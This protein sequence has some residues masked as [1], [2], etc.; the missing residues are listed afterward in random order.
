MGTFR[1]TRLNEIVG[2]KQAVQRI[3]ISLASARKRGEPFPH[4]LLAGPPGL[5]KTTFSCLIGNEMGVK[6]HVANGGNIRSVKDILPYLT[7]MEANEILFIDEIHRI[8]IKVEEFLYPVMEDFK[9]Q[10]V[11]NGEVVADSNLKPFTLIGATTIAGNLSQPMRDRFKIVENLKLYSLEELQ[12]LIHGNAQRLNISLDQQAEKFIAG[13]SRGTPRIANRNLEWIRD[14]LISQDKNAADARYVEQA[15]ALR[16][17][18]KHGMTEDDR[19]YL[20]IL[21]DFNAPTGLTTLAFACNIDKETIQHVIEPY[22]IRL[23]FIAKTPKG[24]VIK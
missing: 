21:R 17:I 14:C 18:D 3:H 12:H 23:G 19:K 11:A 15:L 6:C 10:F 5:G 4:L 8:P 16:G 9:L 22:L 7:K 13:V 1:P 20:K 2:Q 24:R